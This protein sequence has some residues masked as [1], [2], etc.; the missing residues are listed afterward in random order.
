MGH[1]NKRARHLRDAREAKR[2]RILEEADKC[3]LTDILHDDILHEAHWEGLSDSEDESD[4]EI[5]EPEDNI[6]DEG[7]ENFEILLGAAKLEWSPTVDATKFS[8]QRGST[9]C[10]RQQRRVRAIERDLAD[11]AKTHS[12]PLSQFFSA[13]SPTPN[14]VLVSASEPQYQLRREAIEDLE[15]K[16]R[17]KKTVLE[18]QNLTRY[19]A[20]LALLYM[21]QS[22]QDGDTREELS[23]NVARTFNKGL[24][25][26]RKVVEWERS[27]IRERKIP[28][29][30]RGCFAKTFSWFNDEGVQIAVREWCAGAGE[31]KFS[32]HLQ[33]SSY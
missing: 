2:Q 3:L 12:Q 4:V 22:R 13:T 23:Y 16:L 15:K 17:S 18:G 29:G 27:W 28:E 19:R 21:T 31:S 20:V 30:K 1:L 7:N 8:Y 26:A 33:V 24:Y 9:L 6:S 10:K 14:E 11:A 5:S 25:F 32:R